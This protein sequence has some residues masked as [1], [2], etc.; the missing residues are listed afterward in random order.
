[1]EGGIR[2]GKRETNG[3]KAESHQKDLPTLKRKYNNFGSLEI[4]TSL[5]GKSKG[6]DR[7]PGN[8]R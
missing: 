2:A 7:M 4:G 6:E 1:M 5:V 8:Q 3:K